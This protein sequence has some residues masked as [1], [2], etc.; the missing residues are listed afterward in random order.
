MI[1]H[2]KNAAFGTGHRGY[3]LLGS[4]SYVMSGNY[5]SLERA[6]G[7]YT[8][9]EAERNSPFDLVSLGNSDRSTFLA[10]RYQTRWAALLPTASNHSGF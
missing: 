6:F 4:D 2:T 8:I 10:I 5:V 3:L 1:I 7:L 9:L